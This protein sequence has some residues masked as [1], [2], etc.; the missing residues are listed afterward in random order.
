MM[1]NLVLNARTRFFARNWEKDIFDVMI[2][3]CS[4]DEDPLGY[5]VVYV[6][7]KRSHALSVVSAE[8]FEIG[9]SLL[10]QRQINLKKAG[11]KAPMTARAISMIETKLAQARR[12]LASA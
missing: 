2:Q 4:H 5:K 7:K 3:P 6:T 9:A 12:R 10:A 1:D 8:R 11:Y